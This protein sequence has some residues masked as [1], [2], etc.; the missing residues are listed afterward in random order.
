MPRPSRAAT[1]D[2][3][4]GS[5][6]SA[7]VAPIMARGRLFSLLVIAVLG[8]ASM[9]GS[10]A[11]TLPLTADIFGRYSVGSVFGTIFDV[12]Q[13]GAALDSWLGGLLFE[14]TGS[15]GLAFAIAGVQLL[16]AAAVSLTIDAAAVRCPP[17]LRP[18]AAEP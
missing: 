14:L 18:A 16:I 13:A 11:M 5:D 2:E 6:R 12:H 8:G 17:E 10:L 7:I 1:A 3:L 15:Y 9:S 4:S